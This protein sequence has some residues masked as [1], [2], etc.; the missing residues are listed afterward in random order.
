MVLKIVLNF[1]KVGG[2]MGF[3]IWEKFYSSSNSYELC[4]L[5]QAIYTLSISSFPKL[6]VV[7]MIVTP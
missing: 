1:Q 2:S 5:Q 3:G 7:A 6:G 4:D